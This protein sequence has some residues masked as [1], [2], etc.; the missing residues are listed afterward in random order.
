MT[1]IK[2]HIIAVNPVTHAP[3]PAPDW[4]CTTNAIRLSTPQIN[5]E[6]VRGS[7]QVVKILKK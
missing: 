4:Y 3:T 5:Q 6:V 2:R 7:V 1:E